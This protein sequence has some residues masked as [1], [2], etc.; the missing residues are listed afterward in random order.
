MPMA[1]YRRFSLTREQA[2][3]VTLAL[4]CLISSCTRMQ[5]RDDALWWV[6]IRSKAELLLG[7]LRRY[8]W[9]REGV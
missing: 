9:N 3:T 2:E 8:N 7:D 4:E 1:S 5:E 6:S